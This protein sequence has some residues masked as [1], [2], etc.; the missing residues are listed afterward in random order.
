MHFPTSRVS[1]PTHKT[2]NITPGCRHIDRHALLKIRPIIP[3]RIIHKRLT[4][5]LQTHH[6]S[7]THKIFNIHDLPD[8]FYVAEEALKISGRPW[9]LARVFK[10][11]SRHHSHFVPLW[12]W[13]HHGAFLGSQSLLCLL[14]IRHTALTPA[15][16]ICLR[17]EIIII[18]GCCFE[19][20]FWFCIG[21]LYLWI[22]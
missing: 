2:N 19:M 3:F 11:F 22:T 21:C 6:E 15:R 16:L 20:L 1:L 17:F 13:P 12:W 10:R 8:A 4:N 14:A 5:K 9:N 18:I 7:T